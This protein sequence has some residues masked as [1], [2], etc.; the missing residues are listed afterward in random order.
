MT[1][2]PG[3]ED[4]RSN[5]GANA[6]VRSPVVAIVTDAIAPYHR[7]GKEERY[8]QLVPRLAEHLEVHVYTMQWWPGARNMSRD[9]ATYHAICR[10]LPMYR[11]GRR[12]VRQAVLFGLSCR[13]L[14]RARFDVLEAD[15]VPYLQLFVLKL[16]AL[17]RRRR[18]VV[19]WHEVWDRRRWRNY[20][21]PAGFVAWRLERLAMR[22]PDGI[23][24]T[25]PETGE[26]LRLAVG[27]KPVLVAAPGIDLDQAAR[28]APGDPVDL[29]SVGRQVAHKRIDLLLDC[30]RLLADRGLRLSCRIVGD[31]PER[32]RLEQQCRRLGL[33]D[34]VEFRRD[35]SSEEL[36]SFVKGARLFVFPSERE[37]FG[38][39]VLEA[40]ACGTPV[41]TTS[42]PDNLAQHLVSRSARGVVC[43]PSTAALA[44]AIEYA[45]DA[46]LP[47]TTGVLSP[48]ADPP[49]SPRLTDDWIRDY[50]W[51]TVA[52]TI[53]LALSPP[54]DGPSPPTKPPPPEEPLAP[55]QPPAPEE[56][57]APDATSGSHEPPPTDT[58]GNPSGVGAGGFAAADL[59][60]SL[61]GLIALAAL[62]QVRGAWF[63]Q[64]VEL[65]LL[66]SLPG[67]LAL[68]ATGVG[69]A[70]VRA[71]PI[72]I[73]CA[74][75]VVIMAAGLAVD[76]L[77]PPLGVSRPLTTVPLTVGIC[78]A[79]LILI[80][81]ALI[82]RAPS[83][84]VSGP[85]ELRLRDAWPLILPILAWVGAMRLGNGAGDAVAVI[86][87]AAA[88]LAVLLAALRA[89][90]TP[91]ARLGVV[92]Y[93]A[94]LALMWGFSLRGSF[95]YGFDI[96]GEY[97]TFVH[98]LTE[99]RWHPAHVNDAYGAMLS[100]TILPSTISALS[101]AAPLLVLKA[102]YPLLFALFPVAL[103]LLLA[104]LVSRGFAFMGVLFVLVQ[105][106][107]FQQLPAIAR[108]EIGLL[109]FAALTYAIFDSWLRR[110]ART[111][112]L[113]VLA[114][115]VVVA[116]YGTTY[117]TVAL[118]GSALVLEVARRGVG[119]LRS[120]GSRKGIG[121]LAG[122]A[123]L[124][125]ALAITGA[126]AAI[127]YGPVT[128]SAQ[129]LGQF[130][131]DIGDHGLN[132][133]PSAG[134]RGIV[135]A[136]VSGNVTTSVSPTRFS[137]L[138]QQD[139][140]TNHRYRYITPL[141][142]AFLPRNRLVSTP[143]PNP[144]IRSHVAIGVLNVERELVTQLALVLA[145][146]GALLLWLRRNTLPDLRLIGAIGVGAVG[147]LIAVRFSGTIANDYNQT[148]AFLQAMVPLSA[149]L[150]WM[151]E[152][153]AQ[154]Q[155][156][157]LRWRAAIPT[158][159][160]LALGVMLL[161]TSGLRGP[162]LGGGTPANLSDTGDDSERFLVTAPEA[163]AA[164]WLVRSAPPQD[165]VFADRYGALRLTGLTGRPRVFDLLAPSTLDRNAW[166]YADRS[167]VIDGR[168]RGQVDS[169]Y[170]LYAWPRLVDDYWNLVYSNGT[171]AV[172]TRT[173]SG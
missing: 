79:S 113:I 102:V 110:S 107:L 76:L 81:V 154:Y 118:F 135:S 98:V 27:D 169:D 69:A 75:L 49:M 40:I 162:A 134:N 164:Q 67:F 38:I 123:P 68:R 47:A 60:L 167:N 156:L 126:G 34:Q 121:A 128:D 55:E 42:A 89:H 57:P 115:G 125:T 129:N 70:A 101:G 161:T 111:T 46:E 95:V 56:P 23:I 149:C 138:A 82:R 30:L 150:A 99:A 108:Q 66:L 48:E 63:L 31:G 133:L 165:L 106:Y 120:S 96:A 97:Q 78:L 122:L 7:G 24:A 21:G 117:Y 6:A 130:I 136:Y 103:L 44:D 73:P 52:A 43:E 143:N 155:H 119:V 5:G 74:S 12:S 36:L 173:P 10:L 62:S 11:G 124:L 59:V 83:L 32:Q 41:I 157:S 109:L 29:I 45:L 127:W 93:G 20:L 61:A 84:L 28:I 13:K 116:H 80:V 54:T 141:P 51:G 148:R 37:G 151:L 100:L 15:H 1:V 153:A 19:S 3:Q 18:L 171:A 9:G 152:R 65:G 91:L 145:A 92:V 159:Y 35:V 8:Q 50:D 88:S 85:S 160:V 166:V 4:R 86:A 87:A 64:A 104:R 131:D 17:A 58:P 146:F 137:R 22:L 14:M 26:R 33:E 71:F 77:G 144:P 139:F 170:A 163:A 53:A 142:Q 25:S 90:R 105:D 140:R 172:Y 158:V 147:I 168:T 16:V 112:L 132:I 94:G 39:A 114:L 72:Y 2:Q